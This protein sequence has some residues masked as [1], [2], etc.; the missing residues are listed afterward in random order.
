MVI[1]LPAS[2]HTFLELAGFI[3]EMHEHLE[4]KS[5]DSR[6]HDTD[7]HAA[8]DG[9]CVSPSAKVQVFKPSFSLVGAWLTAVILLNTQQSHSG[10]LP[11]GPR[12][13]GP[14]PPELSHW[15]FSF[16]AALPVRAPSLTS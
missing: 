10:A 3:H 7:N 2:S 5:S 15:Q 13:P 11:V 8:A 4:A 1:W 6:E 12:A 9:L 14:A 16:R